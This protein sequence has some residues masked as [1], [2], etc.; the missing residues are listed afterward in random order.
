MSSEVLATRGQPS[1]VPKKRVA[2]RQGTNQQMVYTDGEAGR[3]KST[4]PSKTMDFTL[5]AKYAVKFVHT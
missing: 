5:V 2:G 1:R 3:V 4:F